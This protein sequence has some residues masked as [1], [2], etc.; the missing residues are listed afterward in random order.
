MESLVVEFHKLSYRFVG[1][2]GEESR[3]DG[4]SI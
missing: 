4:T 3:W 1:F 2:F